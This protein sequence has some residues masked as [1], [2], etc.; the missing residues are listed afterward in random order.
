MLDRP[1]KLLDPDEFEAALSAAVAAIA[2][3][4]AVPVAYAAHRAEQ[5]REAEEKRKGGKRKPLPFAE[6]GHARG[7]RNHPGWVM[8]SG[9]R[10]SAIAVRM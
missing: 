3:D 2:L 1:G 5:Q 10:W 4:P 7:R 8:P 6:A 9:C